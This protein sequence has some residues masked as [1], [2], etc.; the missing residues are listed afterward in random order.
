[1]VI[2]MVGDFVIWIKM[3]IKQQL[4]CIHEYKIDRIGFITDL[5]NYRICNK[6]GKIE[7]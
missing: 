7:S 1:M 2:K 6:C 3:F 5:N 4:L